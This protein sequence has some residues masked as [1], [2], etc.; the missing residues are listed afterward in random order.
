MKGKRANATRSGTP[1]TY[2][3]GETSLFEDPPYDISKVSSQVVVHHPINSIADRHSPL[4]FVIKS[5]D[6]QYV[7]LR[8]VKL[9]LRLRILGPRGEELGDDAADVCSVSQNFLHTMFSQVAVYLNDVL[10]TPATPNYP[11]RS[12]IETLLGFSKH[13]K[14]SQAA[15]ALF[16]RDEDLSCLDAGTN[17]GFARRWR[18]VSQSKTVE[19]IGR[20][21]LDIC[22]QTAYLIPGVDVRL[23]FTRSSEDFCLLTNVDRRFTVEIQEAKLLVEKI[24]LLPSLALEH[25]KTL[26]A[27]HQIIMPMRRVEMKTFTIT[28]GTLQMTNEN[29]LTG[30]LPYRI[31]VGILD[32][33]NHMGNFKRNPFY[34]GPHKL[35]YLCVCANG[36]PITSPLELDF[37][38]DKYVEAYDNIFKGL[39]IDCDD[40]GVDVSLKQFKEGCALYVFN[41]ASV[42]EGF[43]PPRHGN[44]KIELK[45]KEAVADALTVLVYAEYPSVL[46]ID[47]YKNISFRDFNQ[48]S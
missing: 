42:K 15:C 14:K 48:F 39:D 37:D 23:V 25:I 7:D 1:Y 3:K 27:G 33:R 12:Y 34:F 36:E 38:A 21:F 24:T 40:V 28:P 13:F 20:P 4:Q 11:Y 46:Q 45:F 32:S 22:A 10:I 2:V 26:E 29:L 18:R 30:L 41:L 9:K 43:I 31:I 17:D 47:R 35:S 44:V 16:E 6:T 19:L 5:N 8:S